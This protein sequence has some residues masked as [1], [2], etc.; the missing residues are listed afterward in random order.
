M[1]QNALKELWKQKT[2]NFSNQKGYETLKEEHINYLKFNPNFN[3]W[4]K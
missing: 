1:P 3:N 2:I 4:K